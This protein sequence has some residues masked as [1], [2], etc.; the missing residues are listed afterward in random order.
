MQ[1]Y[2][3]IVILLMVAFPGYTM[4]C[5]N[6]VW[7]E[8]SF[9]TG[10]S[11]PVELGPDKIFRISLKDGSTPVIEQNS[12]SVSGIG[13]SGTH[14]ALGGQCKADGAGFLCNVKFLQDQIVSVNKTSVKLQVE[15]P[16]SENLNF[17]IQPTME[18]LEEYPLNITSLPVD[19]VTATWD[20]D[21]QYEMEPGEYILDGTT[22]LRQSLNPGL[23]PGP[24]G[25]NGVLQG[26]TSVTGLLSG[27]FEMSSGG[28]E[29]IPITI[30][31]K[32][33]VQAETPVNIKGN[34]VRDV[35]KT[36]SVV[37]KATLECP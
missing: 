17:W 30:N 19:K 7:E 32:L 21:G 35:K 37:F 18:S 22:E 14:Y 31:N 25:A 16:Y 33:N 6:P 24:V 12:I 13:E 3:L 8:G 4:V 5:T 1:K 15:R 9:L 34:I 26:T 2:K 27:Y 23:I 10:E 29:W 36:V 28:G 20:L 11:D